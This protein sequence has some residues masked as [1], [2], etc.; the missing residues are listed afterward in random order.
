M[1]GHLAGYRFEH[2]TALYFEDRQGRET[3]ATEYPMTS[4]NTTIPLEPDHRMI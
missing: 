3:I 1:G 2:S 4:S